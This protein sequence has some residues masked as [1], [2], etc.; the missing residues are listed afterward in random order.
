[1]ES[2][3]EYMLEITI[4]EGARGT[5]KSTVANK[6]RQL[7][8]ET[9]L[10]NPTGFHADGGNGLN[11]IEHYYDAW[12]DMLYYLRRHESSFVFDRFYFSEMVFSKLY[13]EY[14]FKTAYIDY[15]AMLCEMVEKGVN[16]N[17]FFLVIKDEEE[18]KNRLTRDKVPF[19]KV[20]ESVK[21]TLQ[22]QKEYKELFDRL[23][24]GSILDIHYIDTSGKTTNEVYEEILQ[25]KTTK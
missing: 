7:M 22:Q 23:H 6:M 4:L 13:K 25:L 9:T 12:F 18:L 20:E 24:Y 21:E 1:M 15:S 8:P 3:R 5:G 2:R 11:K 17:I 14:D 10:V 19:G 16:I